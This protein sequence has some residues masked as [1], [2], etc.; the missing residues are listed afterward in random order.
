[1]LVEEMLKVTICKEQITFHEGVRFAKNANMSEQWEPERD[2]IHPDA[3]AL[4][5]G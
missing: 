2:P 5:G 4:N 3:V 1:M